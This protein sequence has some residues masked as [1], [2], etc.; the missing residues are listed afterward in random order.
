MRH[1]LARRGAVELTMRL[2]GRRLRVEVADGG[3]GFTP[4]AGGH[5]PKDPG[6]WGLVVV[7]ELVD[8]WGIDASSR[9]VRLVR[10]QRI[11]LRPAR[12]PR[13]FASVWGHRLSAIASGAAE[14]VAV[15]RLLDLV[16]LALAL[17][18]FV[19]AGLPLAGYA[20]GAG[21]WLVQRAIQVTLERRARASDD[22]RTVAGLTASSMIGRAG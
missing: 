3:T 20:A 9:H 7:D 21:A 14:P 22:P 5:D 16:V 17:P 6:G 19:L 1:G 4:P 12:L 15:V 10:A 18:I 8:S 11:E 13:A 2:A